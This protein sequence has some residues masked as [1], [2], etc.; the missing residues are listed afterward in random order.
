MCVS[1]NTQ[2]FI[3]CPAA[4]A[5]TLLSSS[6]KKQNTQAMLK[7]DVVSD[8]FPVIDDLRSGLCPHQGPS[9]DPLTQRWN[10]AQTLYG[11]RKICL[12]CNVGPKRGRAVAD[13][14]HTEGKVVRHTFGHR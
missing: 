1:Q 5:S 10:H 3:A 7:S 8:L 4:D 13:Q 6:A 12:N 2:I 14:M 11:K 9:S